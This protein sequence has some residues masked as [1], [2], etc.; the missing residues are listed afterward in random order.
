MDNEKTMYLRSRK[1]DY[2]ISPE[3]YRTYLDSFLVY[4]V[5]MFCALMIL[6]VEIVDKIFNYPLFPI[7]KTYFT[8]YHDIKASGELNQYQNAMNIFVTPIAFA[9]GYMG[10]KMNKPSNYVRIKNNGAKYFLDNERGVLEYKRHQQKSLKLYKRSGGIVLADKKVDG[11]ELILDKRTEELSIFI[12]GEAGSGKTVLLK[13]IISNW[14]NMGHK[15][16]LHDPKL[17]FAEDLAKANVSM[18][19]IAPW[20]SNSKV[21]DY[22]KMIYTN[23]VLLRNT[24]IDLFIY[25]FAGF[26]NPKGGNDEFWKEGAR[27]VLIALT[28]K[29]V[30]LKK[31][32][33][34]LTDWIDL[35]E[36]HSNLNDIVDIIRKEKPEAA[37]L[38]DK[39]KGGNTAQGIL[40]TT[41]ST[42]N[43]IKN[44][45]TMW[46]GNKKTFDI[47]E[48]LYDKKPRY[49]FICLANSSKYPDVASSV[50][51]SFVNISIALLLAPEYKMARM[52]NL[53]IT[54][55]EFNSFAKYVDI[56]RFKGLMDLGRSAKI[57][58]EIAQQRQTQA[59]EY[60]TDQK[61]AEDFQGAFQNRIYCR[62]SSSDFDLIKTQIGSHKEEW[63]KITS[64]H[65]AQ[66]QSIS[67]QVEVKD[68]N[69]EPNILA[70]RLGPDDERGGVWVALNTV[71]NPV[72]ARI[73]IKYKDFAK[74]RI[75]NLKA[76]GKYKEKEFKPVEKE[77]I[78]NDDGVLES[79]DLIKDMSINVETKQ[80]SSVVSDVYVNNKADINV[81]NHLDNLFQNEDI[82]NEV[83]EAGE[84]L[85]SG[86]IKDNLLEAIDHT[87]TLSLI[88]SSIEIVEELSDKNNNSNN[89]SFDD[90]SEKTKTK[91]AKT[92][93]LEK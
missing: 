24:L 51:A 56:N 39:D 37:F 47:K 43:N 21:I 78:V 30:N 26:P 55:D 60:L 73:L 83:K 14:V 87:G 85:V 32:K 7:L 40:T 1:T 79:A 48:W 69:F 89:I 74:E 4:W 29:L 82:V 15:C 34:I 50:I 90:S 88:N 53:H 20:L 57:R 45:A 92:V 5:M 63:T 9:S 75:D 10:W 81:Y 93:S 35:T 18:A 61:Q 19:L 27:I 68:C 17:E 66:G 77:F 16:I 84:K 8:K 28:R 72:V 67:T 23:N 86:A 36:K 13:Q 11:Y 62:P 12:T 76:I 49:Q 6:E 71:Q 64:N 3:Q 54:L 38:I 70:T 58:I 33:W 65:N 46:N 44:L 80:I 41:V 91:R 2:Q 31:D 22:A 25:S 52:N 42:I 59:N